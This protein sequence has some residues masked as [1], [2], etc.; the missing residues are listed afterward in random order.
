M[1]G[2]WYHVFSRGHN[3]ERIFADRRDYEHF[4]ELVEEMRERFRVRVYAY[5][6]MANH[7]HLLVG[8]PEGNVS[9][10]I[11]W[12][13]GSYGIWCNRKRNRSGHLFGERFKAIVVEDSAWG[14]EV[15]VYIHLNPVATEA[16]GLG[17]RQK[18]AERRGLSAP[19][20]REELDRRL[21]VLREHEWSS[22]GA[23]AGYQRSPGWLDRSVLLRRAGKEGEVSY[24][25]Y[26]ED[27][28]MDYT[29]VAMA[30]RRVGARIQS[31]R[32]LRSA[33]K[34]LEKQCAL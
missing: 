6:L 28:I 34:R 16:L 7:Y 9:R 25:R 3:R 31:D 19:P 1:S 32:S 23:Y 18:A 24:R 21:K 33:V 29:E 17:K 26:V 20:S 22:Y 4:L 13:N 8:T 10:A 11:Q 2:G 30:T 5:C 15:S 12:L 27:R 14:L